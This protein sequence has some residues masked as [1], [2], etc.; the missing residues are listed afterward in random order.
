MPHGALRC[1]SSLSAGI[2]GRLALRLVLAR[3]IVACSFRVRGKATNRGCHCRS[4]VV[5]PTVHKPTKES[6]VEW[7]GLRVSGEAA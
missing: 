3:H 1:G 7:W 4:P 5:A 6:P 2:T